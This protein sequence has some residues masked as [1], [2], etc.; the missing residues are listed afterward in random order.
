MK[1][2]LPSSNMGRVAGYATSAWTT[3]SCCRLVKFFV[4]G[5]WRLALSYQITSEDLLGCATPTLVQLLLL[6]FMF[7]FLFLHK[8]PFGGRRYHTAGCRLEG[9]YG[10]FS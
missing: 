4:A 6:F 1:C 10:R 7:V 5:S 2:P 9:I 8:G 3:A